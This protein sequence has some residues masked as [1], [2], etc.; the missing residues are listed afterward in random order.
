M[1]ACTCTAD[2]RRGRSGQLAPK[3]AAVQDSW[4]IRL[5][6]GTQSTLGS[7][8]GARKPHDARRVACCIACCVSR[9]VRST[10]SSLPVGSRFSA[11]HCS[12]IGHKPV[13]CSC[14]VNRAQLRSAAPSQTRAHRSRGPEVSGVACGYEV[15]CALCRRCTRSS[16]A[17]PCPKGSPPSTVSHPF[18]TLKRKSKW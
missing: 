7:R 2:K 17:R 12:R 6:H 1:S 13:A 18:G 3:A 4:C 15:R 11:S 16:Q 10:R 8:F 9:V 14:D 5:A